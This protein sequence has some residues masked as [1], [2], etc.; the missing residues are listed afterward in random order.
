MQEIKARRVVSAGDTKDR[1]CWLVRNNRL[2]VAACA[3][4]AWTIQSRYFAD[5]TGSNPF[6]R[7]TFCATDDRKNFTNACAAA[8]GVDCANADE[9]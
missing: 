1:A 9:P 8:L 3:V 5:A 4:D 2:R 7:N 6:S